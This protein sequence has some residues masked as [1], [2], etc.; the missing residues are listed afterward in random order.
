M[1]LTA[2]RSAGQDLVGGIDDVLDFRGCQACGE[3]QAHGRVTECARDG[4]VLALPSEALCIVGMRSQ[5]LVVHADAYAGL[6]HALEDGI[7]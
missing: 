5:S 1:S 6:L 3:R 4:E 7:A 2:R